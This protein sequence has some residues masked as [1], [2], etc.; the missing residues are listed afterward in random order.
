M[1]PIPVAPPTPANRYASN[2]TPFQID[3][4][5][6]PHRRDPSSSDRLSPLTTVRS[7]LT[8]I[9]T[10]PTTQPDHHQNSATSPPLAE[11]ITGSSPSCSVSF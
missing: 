5:N 10:H 4:A 1:S 11:S 8:T 7:H 2:G 6:I 9:L 3:T